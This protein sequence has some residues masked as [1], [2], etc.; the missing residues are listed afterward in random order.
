[1]KVP[2]GLLL[3]LCICCFFSD[4]NAQLYKM[5]A[6]DMRLI[7][8]DKNYSYLV[9]HTA[10]TFI[11]AMSFHKKFWNYEPQEKVSVLLNDFTD[12]GNGGTSTIPWNFISVG[13]APFDYTFDI[14]PAN[15]RMQWLMNHELTHTVMTDK[16][17]SSD[18][19]YRTLLS[20]KVTP[21]QSNPLTM[22][23]SYLSTPRWYSPRWFHEGIAVFMETWMSGGMGRTLGGY[24][25]MVFRS[26]VRD[27]MYFYRVAGLETEGT[28]IDFLVG[29]N[30]YLYGTRF[31]SYLAD[32]YG[33]DKLKDFYSRSDSSSRFYASQFRKVYG[34][35][36]EDE[37]DNWIKWEKEFQ[38][39]NLETINKYPLTEYK[40]LTSQYFGSL[41][42]PFLD[43]TKRKLIM[44]VNY[45]GDLAHIV[46]F[47]IDNGV[48][49]R[50]AEVETPLLHYVTSLAYSPEENLLYSTNHNLN[51]RCLNL[52]D[53]NTGEEEQL[54]QYSR[55]GDMIINRSDNS[56]WGIQS[57]NGRSNLVRFKK[58]EGN[59]ETIYTVPFGQSMFDISFSNDGRYLSAT[60]ADVAGDQRLVLFKTSSL[61]DGI[62]DYDTLYTFEDNSASNFI[63]SDDGKYLI[64]TSYYTGVSNVFRIN[65]E[66]KTAELLTNTDIGFFRPVQIS[67]DSLIVFRYSNKG[68]QPCKIKISPIEDAEAISY[69]G[70]SVKDNNPVVESWML[71]APSV[72][73]ID[74]AADFEGS[75]SEM[76]G[77]SLTSAYPVVEGYKDFLAYGMRFNFMDPVMLNS[78]NFTVAYSQVNLLPSKE[79]L[80]I[81]F[82][83]NY[84]NW[85]L[86]AGLNKTD[87]YDLFGPTKYSRAGYFYSVKYRWPILFFKPETMNFSG[88]ISAYGDLDKLPDYQNVNSTFDKMYT[89]L[90]TLDYSYSR[91][92]LGAVEAEQGYDWS[93]NSY[94][95]IIQK[96]LLS[97]LYATFNSGILL[98]VRNSSLWLRTSAGNSFGDRNNTFNNFY[99]GGFGNNYVDHLSAQR[100]R[101]MES[102][103][104]L[105]INEIGGK[106]FGKAVLEWNL[107]PVRFR[108][109]GF[110]SFYSTYARL[111]LFS[112]AVMLDFDDS[113]IRREYYS[114]G[115]QLDFELVLF[116]LLKSNLSFGYGRSFGKTLTPSDEFMISL[117]IM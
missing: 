114:A 79:R 94:S 101:E 55:T 116:S 12:V 35:S 16:A 14:L 70:Q 24:D 30:A 75:Y 62:K 98:P 61:L 25:E 6:E 108:S 23:Y 63:F 21:D 112:Q 105:E 104:G 36:I 82:N 56:L 111:S 3:V 89:L 109:F 45:P 95:S 46:S 102:F 2:A 44:A 31:V 57:N 115:T 26:M 1:M 77:L 5:D 22:M 49:E 64:G 73:N 117:K 91:K 103:P 17:S 67:D 19:F 84:W 83:Y 27:S 42:K 32:H 100:Y 52:L 50:L 38:R 34:I 107:P 33:L 85:E 96:D 7:Y 60:M 37:W 72:I 74:S 41:S 8:I 106:N 92:S 88:R 87:F 18:K 47:N 80:H 59:W 93:I 43:K 113:K 54:V 78:F 40:P 86:K 71:P 29:A 58:S 48:S 68:M 11:N 69:L 99:F 65:I 66:S 15:E 97:K 39:R 90:V 51:W 20:G 110:L 4:V 28:T 9:P 76:K 13:I 10:R 53:L 81:A